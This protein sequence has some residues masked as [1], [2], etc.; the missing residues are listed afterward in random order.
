MWNEKYE[1]MSVA[2]RYYRA[3]TQCNYLICVSFFVYF[4]MDLEQKIAE[5]VLHFQGKWFHSEIAVM[6]VNCKLIVN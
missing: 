1:I 5:I 2:I 6:I 3:N 4:N